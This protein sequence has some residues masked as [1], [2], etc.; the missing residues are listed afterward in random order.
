MPKKTTKTTTEETTQELTSHEECEK[1]IHQLTS[2]KELFEGKYRRALADYQNL[3]RQ[4]QA[5]QSRFVKIATQLFVEQ[6]LQPY[7]HLRMAAKHLKDKGLDIVV[8]QFKQLFESQGLKEIEVMGKAF[9]PEK[10]EAVGTA[11]GKQDTVLE[12]TQSGYEL[13]GVVIRPAKVIVGK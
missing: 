11:E 8:A 2:E 12:V 13:N 6:M 3:E 7:D 4:T 10:M 5:D 1:Q 9:D